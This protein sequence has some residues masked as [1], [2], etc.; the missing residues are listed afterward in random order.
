MIPQ[1]TTFLI[2]E[3]DKATR[4]LLIGD[5]K[6]LG[7]NGVMIEAENGKEAYEKLV[8]YNGK[9]GPVG[10]IIS[11]MVMPIASG[12]DFLLNVRQASHFGEIPFLLLTS[13]S[14]REIVL[15]CAKAKVSSY[16]VKPWNKQTL[17]EKMH[18]CWV[19]HNS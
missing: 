8:E 12:F 3:D 11:D 1:D 15:K 7:F 18:S 5:L 14:D 10:F 6:S 4:E 17:A 19:K 16:L 9:V 13:K 2:A